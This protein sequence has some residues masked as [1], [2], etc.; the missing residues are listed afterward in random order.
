MEQNIWHHF[1]NQSCWVDPLSSSFKVCYPAVSEGNRTK[2][3]FNFVEIDFIKKKKFRLGPRRVSLS[4]CKWSSMA[5]GWASM[6]PGWASIPSGSTSMARVARGR[7]LKLYGAFAAPG[8]AS[9]APSVSLHVSIGEPSWLQSKSS[10]S[11]GEPSWIQYEPPWS[12]MIIHVS[13][14]SIHGSRMCAL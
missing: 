8:W 13:R 6:I 12:E 9:M 11:Q 3:E 7:P 1:E 14:V 5:L 2:I 4:S 10:R